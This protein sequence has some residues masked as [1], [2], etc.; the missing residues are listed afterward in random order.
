M[1]LF[2]VDFSENNLLT[3]QVGDISL[4]NLPVLNQLLIEHQLINFAS[5]STSKVYLIDC[6]KNVELPLFN[7]QIIREKE[8]FKELALVDNDE[9]FIAF[10]NDAYFEINS[11]RIDNYGNEEFVFSRDEDGFVFLL[12][13]S[14]GQLKSLYNKNIKLSDIFKHSEKYFCNHYD[15]NCGYVKR[16][17]GIKSYRGLLFDILNGKTNYKPPLVAEGVFTEGNVPEGDYSIIPPVYFDEPVQIESGSVIG[18][19]T[20]IYKNSLVSENTSIKNSVLFENV[21]I[22]SGC[23]IDGTVCCDN[24]SIKRNSAVFSGSVIGADA[25]IGEDMTLENGSIINKNVKYDKFNMFLSGNKKYIS[26]KDKL[27]GLAPDKCTLLGSAFAVVFNNPKVIVGSDGSPSSLSLK[28]AFMSGLV[29][30]GSECLD[31]GITFKSQM[32]FSSRFCDCDF[33]VFFSGIGG[34]TDIEIF[35]YDNQQLSKTQYCN[36]FDFCNKGEF[37]YKETEKFKNI[38]QI[39]G[40]RRMYI[41]EITAFS[42]DDLPFISSVF[43]ENKILLKTLEEIFRITTKTDKKK[44]SFIVFMNEN[45]TSVNI[46]FNDKLYSQK[47]LERL[48]FFFMKNSNNSGVFE[49]ELYRTLWRFDSVFLVIA[50]LNIVKCTRKSLDVLINEIPSFYIKSNC[51]KVNCSDSEIAEKISF[52][53]KFNHR[54]GSFNIKCD[55]G[56]VKVYNDNQ[57]GKIKVIASSESMAISDELCHRF[58]EFLP[59]L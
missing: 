51:V 49:S 56:Y 11:L 33:S 43:C 44:D 8:V 7:T 28:L 3:E 10:R 47:I 34:G 30:S 6:D 29:A 57:K 19:N 9:R 20:V 54:N 38:R 55:D 12:S 36:L 45:G 35:N 52:K 1:Y 16:L 21:F 31:V 58:T 14:V 59:H 23:F 26:F 42:E 32:F 41:R 24:A 39:R 15:V 17:D 48:V 46:K 27:Q 13:G 50:V 25:L 40:L 37:V 5:L 2:C 18:P 53:F 22:S 4:Y